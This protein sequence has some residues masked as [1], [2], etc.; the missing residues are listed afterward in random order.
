M[1]MSYLNNESELKNLNAG[2]PQGAYLGGIIFIIKF[3]GAFLRPPVPRPIIAPLGYSEAEKAKYID[4]ATVAVSIPLK[5]S[6]ENDPVT[7]WKTLYF[8]KAH[9][10]SQSHSSIIIIEQTC[11]YIISMVCKSK[12]SR[13]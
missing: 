13:T 12:L 11:S 8:L 10:H 2:S 5:K 9:C 4:N 7:I 6:L 3:N 1:K